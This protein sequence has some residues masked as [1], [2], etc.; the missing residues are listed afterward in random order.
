VYHRDLIAGIAVT[1]Q[2]FAHLEFDEF[3]QFLV[4]R[5][6]LAQRHDDIPDADLAGENDVLA[7]LRHDA[8][9][10]GHHQDGPVDLG[11]PGDHVLYVAGVSGHVHMR[12]VPGRGLVF[13]VRDVDGD[14][15]IRLLRGPVDAVG[16]GSVRYK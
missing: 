13:D 4:G 11:R 3:G 1:G 2:Q 5:V 14:A 15:A 12:V 16:R 8:V 7:G 6:G 9:Q 10:R